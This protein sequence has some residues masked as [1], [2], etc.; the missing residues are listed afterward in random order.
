MQANPI[1]NLNNSSAQP[2]A[3]QKK[4]YEA[5][6]WIK[7]GIAYIDEHGNE[8][9]DFLGGR[10]MPL[11][12]REDKASNMLLINTLRKMKADGKE[13][14]ITMRNY[15]LDADG[16]PVEG[17]YVTQIRLNK[18]APTAEQLSL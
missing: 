6:G 12:E 3:N 16:N 11:E 13:P 15:K 5:V 17:S 14:V 4:Q 7:S 10:D 2:T 1:I 9:I 18:E 8:Q